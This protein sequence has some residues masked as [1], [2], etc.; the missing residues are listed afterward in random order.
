[1]RATGSCAAGERHPLQ[2][3]AILHSH[4]TKLLTLD[5][6]SNVEAPSIGLGVSPRHVEE[7]AERLLLKSDLKAALP[8][9]PAFEI[10]FKDPKA[11]Q[12]RRRALRQCRRA[13]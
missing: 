9:L 8:Q 1:M 3:M 12:P 7:H 10:Y 13:T 11:N 5:G 6:S 4:Y 2:V